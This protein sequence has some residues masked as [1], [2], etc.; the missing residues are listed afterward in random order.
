M[1]V[2]LYVKNFGKI[3]EAEINISN[4]SIFV[5]NNNSGKTY[6]MQLIYGVMKHIRVSEDEYELLDV[7][8][9]PLLTSGKVTI[10]GNNISVLEN[11]VNQYLANHKEKIVY[12]IFQKRIT[13]EQ[14]EVRFVLD[15]EECYDISYFTNE[16]NKEV[17]DFESF[18]EGLERQKELLMSC[19]QEQ[20]YTVKVLKGEQLIGLACFFQR[21]IK[22]QKVQFIMELIVNKLVVNGRNSGMFLPASRTG[23]MLL[24]RNYFTKKTDELIFEHSNYN[25]DNKL[26]L[27]MP[28]YEFLRFLQTVNT[29]EEQ[30]EVNRNLINFVEEHLIDGKI[31]LNNIGSLVYIPSQTE[32]RL[33]LYLSSSMVNELT[34]ILEILMA[35][36]KRRFI[37]Y[38]EIETSLH[39]AKQVEMARL[40]NRMN[41]AGY[42]LIVSTHSDTMAT[43]LNN[44]FMLSFEEITEEQRQKKLDK[45]HLT[46]D[47]LLQN[48]N[49]HVYQFINGKDG[50]TTVSELEF[51]KTPYTGYDFSL[52]N[53]NA[54]NLFEESK[55]I[56]GMDE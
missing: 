55:V 19:A 34:P 44:L 24:Y 11:S 33:P 3:K 47:D 26:G 43:K 14:V 12:D 46:K 52:F 53:D 2:Y 4:Y 17:G 28:V 54:M 6:M 8:L 37:I 7:I 9:E 27:T 38:D 10:D 31:E 48:K 13:I 18:L 29:D 41:N 22:N 40:L 51:R 35:E 15:E 16:R 42:K 25:A 30:I 56:M 50:T 20:I 5:G 32:E 23:L 39:P 45:L 1:Q 49:V 36:D 21:N